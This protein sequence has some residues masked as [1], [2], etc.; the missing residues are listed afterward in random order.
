MFT[1][2]RLDNLA[3]SFVSLF[4]FVSTRSKFGPHGS[5]KLMGGL[6]ELACHTRLFCLL[7][8]SLERVPLGT[9]EDPNDGVL[10]LADIL[11]MA[12]TLKTLKVPKCAALNNVVLNGF[13]VPSTSES[14]PSA[15]P[16]SRHFL[17]RILRIVSMVMS[18]GSIRID[19]SILS[20]E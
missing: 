9:G 11:H 12:P 5:R 6:H 1:L 19:V 4:S 15:V 7:A 18:I 2:R 16:A 20:I 8:L 3:H 13:F 10:K 14:F 17:V